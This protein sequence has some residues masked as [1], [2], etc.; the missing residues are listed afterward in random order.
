MSETAGL[1]CYNPR[2]ADSAWAAERVAAIA[3]DPQAPRHAGIVRWTHWI[4]AVCLFA[5]LLTGFEIVISHPRFYWGE[6]GN[7]NTTPLFKIPIPSSR[8]TVPTRYGYVMPD[9]N[10][11]SRALHFEAAW[12]VVAAGLV[13]LLFGIATRHFSKNLVPQAGLSIG[14]V[15]SADARSYNPVQRLTYL[16]VIFVLFPLEIWTGLAMSPAF[17]GAVP[18]AAILLGG[19]QS[20]RT[21]HFFDSLILLLF[22][23]IH[24]AMVIRAGFWRRTRTMITGRI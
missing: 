7:V 9:Q 2:M 10:G 15:M 18:A 13:Y 8:D 5:L 11:W 19:R 23:A 16:I 24:L 4:S 12:V 20:A 6:S 3:A 21:I 22:V 17:T 14:A 1:A